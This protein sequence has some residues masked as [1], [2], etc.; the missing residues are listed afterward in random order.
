MQLI[1]KHSGAYAQLLSIFLA[2]SLCPSA[3]AASINGVTKEFPVPGGITERCVRIE[4]MPG[5]KFSKH[6]LKQE[7]AYCAIDLQRSAVCP[8]LWSTSPGTIIFKLDGQQQDFAAWERQHCREGHHAGDAA[9]DKL[10]SFK[11]SVN[12][13]KTS[14]TWS[15]SSW[16]YYHFSRYFRTH[17]DVPV[18]VYRTMD[19]SQHHERVTAPAL[20]LVERRR[21]L[22]MLKAGWIFLDQ[23]ER[24]VGSSTANSMALTDEGRQV[25]GVL[26]DNKGDRYGAEFNGTRESGWGNGQNEDFQRIAPFIALRSELPVPEAAAASIREAR[27][28]PAMAKSLK[29][30]TPVK[31]VISWMQDVMEITLLDYM[32]GQQDRIGNIDY[33]WRWYWLEDGKLES[34]SAHGTSAPDKLARFNPIRLR[35]SAINDNDAG[36]RHGYANFAKRTGMLDD[37]RHYDPQ[38]Y[39]RLGRLAADMAEE[40]PIYRWMTTS[41]GL[42][43]REAE[44]I[45]NRTIAAFEIL[46]TGCLAGTLALDFDLGYELFGQPVSSDEPVACEVN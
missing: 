29:S 6:D 39:Q 9:V 38:L 33:T 31:Q 23:V 42:G 18:A 32:L 26:L 34:E 20:K 40:G 35:R 14:A 44:G 3:W 10:A 28:D 24:G 30:D 46:Q 22:G 5:A 11:I 13:R 21:H 4:P 41:A 17:T 15:P 7:Q 43:T 19:A 12:D 36:V 16:V 8:K 45:R 1:P 27:K 37:L 2:V 25:F